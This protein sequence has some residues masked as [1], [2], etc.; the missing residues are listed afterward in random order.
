MGKCA[1][2]KTCVQIIIDKEVVKAMDGAIETLNGQIDTSK[3]EK[4]ITRSI[5]IENCLKAVFI[6]AVQM[7]VEIEKANKKGEK[8]DA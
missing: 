3:G 7:K 6:E 1:F 8:R 4:R 5:F 2:N